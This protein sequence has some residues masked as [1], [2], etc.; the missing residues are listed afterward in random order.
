MFLR[1]FSC[2]AQLTIL[3]ESIPKIF[4]R[5]QEVMR[6]F[7]KKDSSFFPGKTL[8]DSGS[9]FLIAFLCRKK[10][11]KDKSSSGKGGERKRRNEGGRTRYTFH[12]DARVDRLSH[13]F[14]PRVT[15]TGGSGIRNQGDILSSLQ[16]GNQVSGFLHFVEFMVCRHRCLNGKV[17]QELDGI[18][19]IFRSDA[20]RFF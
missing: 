20:I 14:L 4:K 15:D 11:L 7:I 2:E 3:P 17:I 19:G 9:F 1:Q 16:A 13:Q 12:A 5:F 18:S 10:S 8:Q 6:R